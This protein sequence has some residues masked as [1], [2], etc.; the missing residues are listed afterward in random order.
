[1]SGNLG[2]SG[3]SDRP[4]ER[5]QRHPAAPDPASGSPESVEHE[6][7]FPDVPRLRLEQLIGELTDQAQQVL[8]AQG[9]LRA[10]VRA[11]ADVIADLSLPVVL[12]RI[13]TAARELVGARYGALGVLGRRGKLEQF[14]HVGMDAETVA[15][16]G[17]LPVGRG[18]LGELISSPVPLRIEDLTTHPASTGFPAGHPPMRSFLGVPIRVRGEVFG[19]LYLTDSVAGAF[20]DEDE[21]LLTALAATAGIA[22]AN[23]RLHA[24]SEQHRHWLA[25]STALTQELLGGR[26]ASPVD[27]VARYAQQGATADLATVVTVS[28]EEHADVTVA[29]GIMAPVQ[30]QA[31]PLDA[32]LV[33]KVIR[34][35]KPVLVSEYDAEFDPDLDFRLPAAVGS[36]IGVPL[37][38]A[39]GVVFGALTVG[40]VPGRAPF[41]ENDRDQLSGFGGNAGI[42][43]E[44]ERARTEQEQLRS[45][46]DHDRIGADLHDHVIQELFAVGMGLQGMLRRL[47]NQELKDRVSGYVTALDTTISQVRD[48]IYRLGM[49]QPPRQSLA[50]R[51]T[52]VIEQQTASS[53]L[54]VDTEYQDADVDLDPPEL[55][56]D[57]VAVTREALSNAVRH[58]HATAVSIR[59]TLT[60][61]TVTVE[62]IDN[63][64]GVGTPTRSSGL[65]NLTQRA[66]AHHGAFQITTPP[67]GGTHLYWTAH[68]P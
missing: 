65:S 56:D 29:T 28:D 21:Q 24:D 13:V 5:D 43:L 27:L 15:R 34:T 37:Q 3:E 42:A 1:M 59:I 6:L 4:G 66:H 8:T 62:I 11:N 39:D 31:V 55:A 44:L 64:V 33:G 57:V 19:N 45:I 52:D 40:R 7:T 20:T 22:I 35:G 30:G 61:D 63:G 2:V 38:S 60:D 12:R 51:L 54:R 16:I 18:I 67:D 23:A 53:G 32:S 41:T 47:P 50:Q 17:D 36:V 49:G 46:Q 14:V 9:R 48:T 26:F 68:R 58:A 25:A 10:L